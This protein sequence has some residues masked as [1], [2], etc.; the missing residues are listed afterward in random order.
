MEE[1]IL[2][3]INALAKK[4]K[5]QGLTE[6]ELLERDRLRQQYLKNFR[7]NMKTTILDRIYIVE[8]D[9]TQVKLTETK[10]RG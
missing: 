10:K 7:K 2:D 5:T 3:R 1:N 6:E 9:G 8:E 4:A